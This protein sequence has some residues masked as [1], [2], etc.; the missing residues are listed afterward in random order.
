MRIV[1]SIFDQLYLAGIQLVPHS[2]L[3]FFQQVPPVIKCIAVV[4]LQP[5][6]SQGPG[7]AA[8][9]RQLIKRKSSVLLGGSTG[10]TL[11]C[12]ADATPA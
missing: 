10:Y 11:P 8:S 12:I 7:V 3:L 4:L 1:Q 6:R 2:P 5:L 9:F